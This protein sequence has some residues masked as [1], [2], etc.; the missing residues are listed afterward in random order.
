[1]EDNTGSVALSQEGALDR[2]VEQL[3]VEK[4]APRTEQL[5]ADPLRIFVMNI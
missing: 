2:F 5:K 4:R 1:M 3:I